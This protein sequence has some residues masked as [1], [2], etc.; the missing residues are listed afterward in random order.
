MV[1]MEIEVIMVLIVI[2]YILADSDSI[3]HKIWGIL[4]VASSIVVFIN[5][6]KIIITVFSMI[7]DFFPRQVKKKNCIYSIL[8]RQGKASQPTFINL[9]IPMLLRD[10]HPARNDVRHT[11]TS[12][13]R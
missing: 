11:C 9:V 8:S 7:N 12:H 1:S 3:S 10:A 4:I 6:N 5:I 2:I 13:V